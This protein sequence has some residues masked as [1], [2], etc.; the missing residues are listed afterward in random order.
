MLE[1]QL[2]QVSSLVSHYNQLS[3]ESSLPLTT[4]V[5]IYNH[6]I[7]IHR[8][9]RAGR[10]QPPCS[11]RTISEHKPGKDLQDHQFRQGLNFQRLSLHKLKTNRNQEKLGGWHSSLNTHRR[12]ARPP[13]PSA[14]AGTD[15]SPPPPPGRGHNAAPRTG[16]RQRPGGNAGNRL[17]S[18][19][20][21]AM[22]AP[23]GTSGTF[24]P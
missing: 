5:D 12:R 8:M 13:Q 11:T 22:A 6:R 16:P 9:G 20:A 10:V 2:Y 14:N 17:T 18:S 21:T 7:L 1:F 4:P 23:R 24:R 3:T 15:G 19:R